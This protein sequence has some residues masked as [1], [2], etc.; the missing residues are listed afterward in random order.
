MKLTKVQRFSVGLGLSTATGDA[1]RGFTLTGGGDR[2]FI[3]LQDYMTQ[4]VF[5]AWGIQIGPFAAH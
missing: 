1:K 5:G 4:V 3:Q 2:G